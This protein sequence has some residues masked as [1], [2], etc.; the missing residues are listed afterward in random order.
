MTR[1]LQRDSFDPKS[2]E[3]RR[4]TVAVF[5]LLVMAATWHG[6]RGS[7]LHQVA[8]S[9][10]GCPG[11]AELLAAAARRTDPRFPDQATLRSFDPAC[12]DWI[13]WVSVRETGGTTSPMDPIVWEITVTNA[14]LEVKGV[15]VGHSLSTPPV[16]ADGDGFCEIVMEVWVPPIKPEGNFV[17]WIVLRLGDE[18]NEIVCLALKDRGVWHSRNIRPKPVWRDEDGDGQDEFVFIT[19]ETARTASGGI[20]FKPPQTIAVFKW[21]KPGGMLFPELLPDDAG[22]VAWTPPNGQPVRVEPDAD[23]EQI[24]R[25]LLPVGEQAKP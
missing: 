23:L 14:H 17:W 8:R 12:R 11:R 24:V 10:I 13:A 19:V 20:V 5:T 21:D 1:I 16:D 4:I 3:Y 25:K 18:Y 15:I 22:I 2:T 9:S 7:L 6:M